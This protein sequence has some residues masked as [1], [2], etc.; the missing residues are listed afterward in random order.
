MEK[1]NL[2]KGGCGNRAIYKGWCNIK[3]KKGN[4]V[5]VTCSELEKKR[6]K[7]ISI[8]RIKEA[9]LGLNPMQ[10]PK[11]CRKNHSTMRNI[12][13]SKT[14]KKLGELKLLPQQTESKELRERRLMRIRKV[15][16]RLAREGRLNHQI[17]SKVKKTKRHQKIAEALKRLAEEKKLP[18]QNLSEEDKLRGIR[19]HGYKVTLFGKKQIKDLRGNPLRTLSEI[20]ELMYEKN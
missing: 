12:K 6:I 17:E 4:R 14:L 7:A 19:G 8:F 16:K 20:K 5:C 1:I 9:K 11:I 2:C 18:M 15:L 10:N 3:W 13:A